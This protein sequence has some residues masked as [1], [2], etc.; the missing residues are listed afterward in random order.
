[1]QKIINF[2][3]Y[4]NAAVIIL[5]IILILGGG[6]LAAGPENIGVKQTSVEGTDNT[7]LLSADLSAFNMDFK[8]EKI[9]QDE[10][11]YY[12]T[13][14]YLDLTVIDS[15]WQY[16]LSSKTQ[17]ISKKIREDLGV[18][19][20]KFLAKHYQARVRELKQAK[21]EA[22]SLGEQRRIEV[23]EYSG[24]I[25]LT[26]DLAAKVFPGYE[27][28]VKTEL[29]APEFNLPDFNADA[30]ENSPADNLTQIYNDYI[31]AHPE[32]FTTP[33]PDDTA[34]G[35]PETV[36]PEDT[37]VPDETVTPETPPES[38]T[39]IIPEPDSVDIIELPVE[40]PASETPVAEPAPEA[41]VSESETAPAENAA[42]SEP[43]E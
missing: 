36:V 31:A 42:P 39:P 17:K 14:S 2:L 30:P 6:A 12:A 32:I 19:L 40:E 20:A 28:I 21:A 13:Y 5:A 23:T 29:P 4:N 18:Y 11:Y 9:E 37:T 38:E 27:P 35:T 43:A 10:N 16:Q 3:K 34:S 7:L 25:G 26:L 41:P 22:E 15:A 8:I 1:M 24:L 33:M